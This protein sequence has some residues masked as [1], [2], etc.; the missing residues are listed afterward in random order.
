MKYDRNKLIL[1]A[2]IAALLVVLAV[3]VIFALGSL[4]NQPSANQPDSTTK[5]TE[6]DSTTKPSQQEKPSPELE[7]EDV[8]IETPYGKLYMPGTWKEELTVSVDQTDGYEV[9]FYGTFGDHDPIAL[10]AVNF[11]GSQGTVVETVYTENNVPC[12][13]RLRTFQLEMEGW[14]NIDQATARAMQEDLN[15]LLAK[16][17][18][19]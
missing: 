16:L 9:V 6:P 13:V 18:G 10:F 19:E 5:A 4:N 11:G 14:T 15:H 8:V 17:R 7:G 12:D 2:A 3:L 1:I